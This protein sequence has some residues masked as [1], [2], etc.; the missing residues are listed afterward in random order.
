MSVFVVRAFARLREMVA[1]RRELARRLAELGVRFEDHDEK[2]EVI[3]GLMTPPDRP[4]NKIHPV[5]WLAAS[6]ERGT[7]Q[8][9]V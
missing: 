7:R 4:K 8:T 6:R 5:E 2:I 9:M 1:T 3:R